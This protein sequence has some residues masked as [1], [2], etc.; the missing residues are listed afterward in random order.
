MIGTCKRSFFFGEISAKEA[1]EE[2]LR[3]YDKGQYLIRLSQT[4]AGCFVLSRNTEKS[5]IS[6]SRIF[7]DVNKGYWI[8]LVNERDE[9]EVIRSSSNNITLAKFISEIKGTL[10]LGKAVPNSKFAAKFRPTITPVNSSSD[11]D[12]GY[13]V[14]VEQ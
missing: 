8:T 2:Y 6:H 12:K 13:A 14:P 1:E 7:F 9:K 3:L 5:T 11:F 4:V 10:K